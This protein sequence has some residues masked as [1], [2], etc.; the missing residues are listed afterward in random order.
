VSPSKATLASTAATG[1]SSPRAE[2]PE[3]VAAR[4]FAQPLRL[5]GATLEELARKLERALPA[6]DSA[7]KPSLGQAWSVV[8]ERIGEANARR[9]FADAKEPRVVAFFRLQGAP[10]SIAWSTSSA[11]AAV[12][13]VLGSSSSSSPSGGAERRLSRIEARLAGDLLLALAQAAAKTLGLP[14]AEFELLTDEAAIRTRVEDLRDADPH[15]LEIDLGLRGPTELAA[16]RLHVGG[17]RREVAPAPPAPTAV[18]GHLDAIELE[19]RARLGDGEIPLSQVLG[20]E[21]GDVI[22]IS[23]LPALACISVEGRDFARARLGT[24]Q[25]RLALRIESLVAAG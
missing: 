9:F 7:L 2:P 1:P 12:D 4:D 24:H 3:N 5:D 10:S 21:A 20:L 14:L 8:V 25:G 22:P 18:P 16:P 17:L 6:F 13:A 15:R 19:L 23:A 11:A